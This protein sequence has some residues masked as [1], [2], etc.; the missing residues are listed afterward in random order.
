MSNNQFRV[1]HSAA[2]LYPPSGILN[3]MCWEQEAAQELDI[4][5]TTKMYCPINST[6]PN[7]VT[8]FDCAVDSKKI[9]HPFLK[10]LAWIRL[11][12]NYYQWL[13]S[14]QAEV[15]IFVLRYYVHDPFQLWFVRNSPKPVYFVHH[16]LEV[17]ELASPAGVVAIIRSRL[18]SLLAR[19]TLPYAKGL[20]GVTEEIIDY[21]KS[22][23][24][25]HD[26][27]TYVYPNGILYKELNIIDKRTGNAPELLFVANF[28]PWHGLDLLLDSI[29]L[30]QESFILHLV[31]KI[32]PNLERQVNSDNRIKVH[33]ILN[34]DEIIELSQQCWVG[35]SC[36]ALRRKRMST[37]CPIKVREYLM[38]GLPVC[39]ELDVFPESFPFYLNTTYNIENIIAFAHNSLHLSKNDCS[40]QA[41]SYIDK[42]IILG[43]LFNTIGVIQ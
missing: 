32:P 16:S 19:F 42:K 17:P 25:I 38:L 10:L 43:S 40:E 35:L 14:M 36:F 18:E 34:H 6:L 33:G 28:C 26:K 22:R 8:Y 9:Q 23:A 21:E 29:K 7:V 1:L 12:K 5:W 27:P 3:Q 2:L 13:M 4:P 39:G 31:G 15:D 37:A 20:I 11:R 24:K 41:K 30:S